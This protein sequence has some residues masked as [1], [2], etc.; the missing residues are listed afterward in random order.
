MPLVGV[1]KIDYAPLL[2]VRV[3][4]RMSE[5][6][7]E[8]V[9]GSA[10]MRGTGDAAHDLL[11]RARLQLRT[12][13]A[14]E[15][16]FQPGDPADAIYLL[17]GARASGDGLHVDPLVQ[18]EL[19]PPSGKRSLRFERVVHGEVFGELEL[20]EQ[21]LSAKAAKR[22]TSAFALT[23]ASVVPLPLALIGALMEADAAFRARLIRIGSQRLLAA[24][25]QQHEKGHI[26]PDLLLADWFV[27]LSADIGIAEGNRVRFPRK[28]AQEHI[29][30]DLGVSRETISR[31][32]NEWERSGLLRTGAR[33]QQIEILDYQR[34][35]RL[36]SLRSVR[37]R[38][39]L[40]RTIDDID[41]A[42][43]SGDLIR[44]RNIGLDILRYY[45]SSPELHHRTA[46]AA[47]RSGDSKGAL[48]L[49]VRSGLPMAG[50]L[51]AL[52]DA[53]RKARKNPFLP[54]ERI[55]SEPF[56]DDGYS[57]DEMLAARDSNGALDAER[58]AQLVED[59]AALNARL[60]KEQAFETERS[61]ER[62]K[63][64]HSSFEA[65]HGLYAHKRGYYPGVN[66]ATMALIAGDRV[67]A[68]KIADGLISSLSHDDE[69]YWPLATLAE[70]LLLTGREEEAKA[71]LARARAARGADD[72]AKATTILQFRRLQE[73]LDADM[74]ACVKVLGPR[75]V[76][77]IS[78][79]IFRGNEL[80]ESA[81]AD[82][83]ASI[84]KRAEELLT[85]HRV[86][87]VYGALAAGSDIILAETAL[88]LGAEFDVVL[89]FATERF[90]ETS[91][92]VGDPPD[93]AGKW[94]KRFRAILDGSGGA[95]SLTIMDPMEPVERDL[96][97][98]FF[99]AFR[100]AAGCA[101]QRAAMLQ[102]HCRLLAVADDI[103][104]DTV[105]GANRVV[106][107]WRERR[108]EFDLIP[109]SHQRAK[110]ATWE[111]TQHVF[112]PVVFLWDAGVDGKDGKGGPEKLCKAA[113]KKLARIERT[114]RDGRR[115]ICLIAGSTE[116]ALKAALAAAEA[117]RER[118]LAVRIICDFGPVLGSDL[119]PDKKLVARLQ[120]A[121]DL[122]GLPLDCVLATEAYA[123]QAKFDLGETVRLVPVGRAE[124]VPAAEEGERQAIRSRPS[125]PIYTAEWARPGMAESLADPSV[126]KI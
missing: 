31:R 15:C 8:Q 104:P 85:A 56:V 67:V 120:S 57:E 70:A 19:K 88:K 28:I 110:R 37:S 103:G 22:T 108:R 64:A 66:A 115:G 94:E 59:I 65:Y 84:R 4:T 123:A 10:L 53:V 36:A 72:G 16:V 78:G 51:A 11:K 89:P 90:I 6:V 61:A 2:P 73:A 42:I 117:A 87:I 23:P 91:V 44:A 100:Y 74:E 75:T 111:E 26:Y 99:Y 48:E 82:A 55:L 106:A 80:D 38:A 12:L 1:R 126:A 76:A 35:S 40:E 9:A 43:A 58:E 50:N 96:D 63:R 52:E 25:K 41:A 92:R 27:E 18:V 47:A 24:L 122:P 29:A 14:G 102:T 62:R 39:A 97:G 68:R 86:G 49:L 101:L 124:I 118:R 20:L 32:L 109:F 114:H 119:E 98:Y 5:S 83:E 34:I 105:A 95:R 107:D 54:M 81:Q 77:V 60:L 3:P 121:D 21:G 13:A 125:L 46:L 113:G 71:V 69:N 30:A 79:H 17:L 45:P 33:S 93:H 7:P 112:R 116:E